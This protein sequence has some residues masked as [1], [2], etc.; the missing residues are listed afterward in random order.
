MNFIIFGENKRGGRSPSAQKKTKFWA[1][2]NFWLMGLPEGQKIG[3]VT[4]SALLYFHLA[5]IVIS[6]KNKKVI[7]IESYVI[8]KN[9]KSWFPPLVLNVRFRRFCPEMQ[10]QKLES[11]FFRFSNSCNAFFSPFLVFST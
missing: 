8:P 1:N 11:T 6:I 7:L 5:G 9:Q 4:I 2:K 3:R 10:S